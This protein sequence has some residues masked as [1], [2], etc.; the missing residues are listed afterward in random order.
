MR[1]DT[2]LNPAES[3]TETLSDAYDGLRSDASEAA[4][5]ARRNLTSFTRA[6][7]YAAL[8]TVQESVRRSRLGLRR[9]FEWPGAAFDRAREAPERIREAYWERADAGEDLVD[10]A[11][12]RK[13]TRRARKHTT[14]ATRSAKRTANAARKAVKAGRQ[15]VSD[16]ASALDPNDTRA[17]EDRTVDELYALAAEREID[18]RSQMNKSELI[19]A[20]R[21]KRS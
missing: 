7:P 18:G 17:Y 6:L 21:G 2:Y 8:G 4:G 19:G 13:S 11:L 1:G 3:F 14:T 5:E 20:L 10:R 9:A 12:H 15:A 16:A